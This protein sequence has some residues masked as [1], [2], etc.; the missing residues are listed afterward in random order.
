MLKAYATGGKGSSA[1]SRKAVQQ[2][3]DSGMSPKAARQLVKRN[4]NTRTRT[5]NRQNYVNRV[6]G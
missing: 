6:L 2:A 3:I 5:S 4:A 1:Y